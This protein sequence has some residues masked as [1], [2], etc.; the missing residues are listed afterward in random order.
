MIKFK[1]YFLLLIAA[2]VFFVLCFCVSKEETFTLNIQATYYVMSIS[3][4][5]KGIAILCLTSGLVYF[6]LDV[7]KVELI[8]ILSKV[9]VFGTLL[10]IVAL[11]FFNYKNKFDL[12]STKFGD[13]SNQLDYNSYIGITLMLILFLQ[14]FFLINIF[15]AQIKKLRS[16]R[17][18]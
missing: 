11:I 6:V 7:S 9:H 14:F 13:I 1:S 16:H 3:D 15:V 2:L 10:S 8:S 4:F 5:Y 17:I 12:N 18:S